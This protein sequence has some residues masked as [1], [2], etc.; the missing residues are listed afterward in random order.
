[1]RFTNYLFLMCIA[2]SLS[3]PAQNTIQWRNDRTGIYNETGLLKSWPVNGP[4]LLW[5]YDGLGDGFSSVAIDSNKIYITGMTGSTGYIYVLDLNG[6]LLDKKEYGTEW[7]RS[8]NGSRG[9]VTVNEGKLYVFTGTGNLICMNQNT[10]DI[11]WKKNVE[12]DFDGKNIQWGMN[13]SP[14]IV[15]EKVILSP[16]GKEHNIVALNKYDG[17]IIWSCP[18]EGDL[19]AYCSPL[20]LSNQQIPQ[21][22]TMMAS[23][24]LGIDISNGKK[25]WSFKYENIRKIHPNTPVYD[26]KDM[27]LFTAGYDKGAIMLRLTNG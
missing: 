16:G 21:I 6:K 3:L 2:L 7:D 13:E 5:H 23:N 1:M 27:L 8:Y 11:I 20:Y 19:S 10:L 26:G 17:S 22:V 12:T 24:I 14:L 15:N 9:T 18:G 4:E 25:L